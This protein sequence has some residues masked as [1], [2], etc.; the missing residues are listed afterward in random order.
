MVKAIKTLV[1]IDPA[2]WWNNPIKKLNCHTKLSATT[3]TRKLQ[4][5]KSMTAKVCQ[6]NLEIFWKKASF[7][8]N[9]LFIIRVDIRKII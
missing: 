3:T 2:P 6:E 8:Q 5:N 7:E 1:L 9:S 4:W